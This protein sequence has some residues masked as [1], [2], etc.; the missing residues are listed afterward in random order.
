MLVTIKTNLF[1]TIKRDGEQG[2]WCSDGGVS[3]R[4]RG[5]CTDRYGLF[6]SVNLAYL[7]KCQTLSLALHGFCKEALSFGE[8]SLFDTIPALAWT[9]LVCH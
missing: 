1:V 5:F 8:F 2:Q 9:N 7:S 3:A 6:A 4:S